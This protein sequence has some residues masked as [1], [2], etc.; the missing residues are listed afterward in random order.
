MT[1][2]EPSNVP[3]HIAGFEDKGSDRGKTRA[4]IADNRR[5][6]EGALSPLAAR[7]AIGQT[8]LRTC[9]AD[10][11]NA[12]TATGRSII[13]HKASWRMRIGEDM[14]VR[15]SDAPDE[16]VLGTRLPEQRPFGG[17]DDGSYFEDGRKESSFLRAARGGQDEVTATLFD[18]RQE[19]GAP[20]ESSRGSMSAWE[21]PRHKG[22]ITFTR[23]SAR[24]RAYYHAMGTETA[25][26][27]SDLWPRTL[28]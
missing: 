23:R 8:T 13:F 7:A 11:L 12:P 14:G 21:G 18:R 26:D 20:D 4:W 9:C 22:V 24:Q 17:R 5:A 27:E 3:I 19:D 25:T 15:G 16:E 1:G 6:G 10:T 2:T 28:A